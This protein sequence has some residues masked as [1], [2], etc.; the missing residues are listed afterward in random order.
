MAVLTLDQLKDYL[1]KIIMYKVE[2][3]FDTDEEFNETIIEV[4]ERDEGFSYDEKSEKKTY[5]LIKFYTL[6]LN[7]D[8]VVG[9]I[10]HSHGAF[11]Q[12]NKDAIIHL[13]SLIGSK[14]EI[15]EHK[16]E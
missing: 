8:N 12:A 7:E 2:F 9:Y 3:K 10:D 16:K 11:T 14:I 5:S 15:E 6:Y 13:V 4:Y 1:N